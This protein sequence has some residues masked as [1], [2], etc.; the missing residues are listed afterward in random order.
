VAERTDHPAHRAGQAVASQK[1]GW[2]PALFDFAWEYGESLTDR[3]SRGTKRKGQWIDVSTGSGRAARHNGGMMIQSS[4]GTVKPSD[5]GPGDRGTTSVTLQG[6]PQ[7][8]GRWEVR[9]ATWTQSADGDPYDVHFDL[10]PE[11]GG[12]QC[13]TVAKVSTDQDQVS[14]GASNGGSHWSRTQSGIP[15]G[16]RSNEHA[17]AVE[18]AKDHI[19]W[20]VDGNPV[21]TLKDKSAI[22]GVPMTIRLSL[23]GNGNNEMRH[24]YAIFDW[25]RGFPM[26]HGKQ[27]KN[28][29]AL[30]GNDDLHC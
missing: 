10:V 9:F 15:Q 1:Y 21:G 20:F 28:G 27:I 17:Y 24:T 29:P 18:L 25:M 26:D 30:N 22:P 11:G 6:N 14:F 5:A 2:Q 8:Y 7:T 3:P 12:S 19:T 16:V 23:V 4:Y 13:I